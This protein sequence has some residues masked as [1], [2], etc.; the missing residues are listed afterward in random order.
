M[1]IEEKVMVPPLNPGAQF[2]IPPRRCSKTSTKRRICI[3]SCSKR[4]VQDYNSFD[5]SLVTIQASCFFFVHNSLYV[6][7]I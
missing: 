6:P 3:W 1:Y 2:K 4:A 7:Y 5:T